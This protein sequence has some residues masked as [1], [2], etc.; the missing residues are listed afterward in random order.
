MH[1]PIYTSFYMFVLYL[2]KLA[3]HQ[4]FMWKLCIWCGRPIV[5]RED[6]FYN[7]L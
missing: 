4:S 3:T 6:R 7:V 2:V 1:G 5:C